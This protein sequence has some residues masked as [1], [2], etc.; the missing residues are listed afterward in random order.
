MQAH[1]FISV[2]PPFEFRLTRVVILFSQSWKLSY[3]PP[4]AAVETEAGG[5]VQDGSI[6]GSTPSLC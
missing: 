1:R 6:P 3:Y 5:V 2:Q 4:K